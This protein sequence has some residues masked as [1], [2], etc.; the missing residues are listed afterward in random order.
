MTFM[1]KFSDEEKIKILSEYL[2]GTY[3]FRE[4]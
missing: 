3:G 1:H 2:D 4:I